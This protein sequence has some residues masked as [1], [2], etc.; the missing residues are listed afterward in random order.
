LEREFYAPVYET[1][2]QSD[3]RM[4]DFRTTLL[5][6]PQVHFGKEE[7]TAVDFYTSDQKGRYVVVVEGIDSQGNTAVARYPF[8]VK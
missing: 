5:W 1:A 2:Q 6:K 8:E 7:K 3:S 4:P